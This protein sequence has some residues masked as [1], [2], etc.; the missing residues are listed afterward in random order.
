MREAEQGALSRFS[1][2]QATAKHWPTVS[3][4]PSR[5]TSSCERSRADPLSAEMVVVKYSSIGS[6]TGLLCQR[7]IVGRATTL[8]MNATICAAPVLFGSWSGS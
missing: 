7:L 5:N 4:E 8:R 1:F 6:A 3:E 2:N